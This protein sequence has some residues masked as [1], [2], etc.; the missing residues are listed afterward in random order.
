MWNIIIAIID[1]HYSLIKLCYRKC[2]SDLFG[3]RIGYNC[4]VI[5][6]QYWHNNTSIN[7]TN[8][9]TDYWNLFILPLY[10]PSHWNTY[11]DLSVIPSYSTNQYHTRVKDCDYVLMSWRDHLINQRVSLFCASYNSLSNWW[12]NNFTFKQ[13]QHTETCR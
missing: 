12:V 11:W 7:L 2:W 4:C 5:D 8:S 9:K 1:E 6:K 10:I 3:H 13:Y